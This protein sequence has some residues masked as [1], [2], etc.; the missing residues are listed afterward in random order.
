[1]L[2]DIFILVMSMEKDEE[3]SSQGFYADGDVE[4]TRT[5]IWKY[6][7]L[8][9]VQRKRAQPKILHLS[10]CDSTFTG[11]SSTRSL[12]RPVLGQKRTNVGACVPIRKDDDNRYAQ[13]KNAQKILK[14]IMTKEQLLSSC[15]TTSLRQLRQRSWHIFIPIGRQ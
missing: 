1:M 2:V 4:P 13:F 6:Y 8:D 3:L 15:A 9:G 7:K 12:G 11:C 5:I 14:E 10:L